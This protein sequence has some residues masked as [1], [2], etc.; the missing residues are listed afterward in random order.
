MPYSFA[1]FEVDGDFII[2]VITDGVREWHVAATVRFRGDTMILQGFH[3]H[4]AGRGSTGIARLRSMAA[5]LKDELSVRRLRIEG[6]PRTSGAGP[7]RIP[8]PVVF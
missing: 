4:G 3:M 5:W 8:R 2:S 1:H 7:G 6:S